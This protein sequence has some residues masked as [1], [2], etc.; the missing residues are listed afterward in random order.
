MQ[1][2]CLWYSNKDN[3]NYIGKSLI[4]F[5]GILLDDTQI[6][7]IFNTIKLW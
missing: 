3:Q 4:S 6:H 2:E 7:R 5:D 1:F